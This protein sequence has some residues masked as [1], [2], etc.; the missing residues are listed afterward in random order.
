MLLTKK[1]CSELLTRKLCSRVLNECS[2]ICDSV[3]PEKT[4]EA[5]FRANSWGTFTVFHEINKKKIIKS[6]IIMTLQLTIMMIPFKMDW[7][8]V[9]SKLSEI[10][11]ILY[12][13]MNYIASIDEF[14]FQ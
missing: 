1:E 7:E 3:S 4:L 9:T 14:I 12:S 13:P 2:C 6:Y 8:V 11:M 5:D 10:I